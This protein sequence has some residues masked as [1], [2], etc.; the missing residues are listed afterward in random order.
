MIKIFTEN[1]FQMNRRLSFK[2]K[3]LYMVMTTILVVLVQF[4]ANATVRRVGY[5]GP[6][7][8]G[9]DYST[10]ALAQT[11]SA[12][13]D[14]IYMFRGNYGSITIT[15]Q[16]TVI[17]TGYLLDS[18]LTGNM[19]GN[20]FQQTFKTTSN[21]SVIFDVGSSNSKLYGMEGNI[22]IGVN[23][24]SN[25]SNIEIHRCYVI[26]SISLYG[27]TLNTK[28]YNC[29]FGISASISNNGTS[30]STNLHIYNCIS[31][32]VSDILSWTGNN[33]T[34]EL[35]NST[36]GG[37]S[38]NN[39]SAMV[40]YN[41]IFVNLNASSGNSVNQNCI[42]NN[43]LIRGLS[44]SYPSLVGSSNV[45]VPTATF[46]ITGNVMVGYPSQLTFS[47]D[48][49]FQLSASSPAI[50][51]GLGGVNA[52]AYGGTLPYKLSGIPTIPSIYKISSPQG[53]NPSGN[54]ITINFSTKGNN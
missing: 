45:Y 47:A 19:K 17:G 52:G 40:V 27:T 30:T 20:G 13:G 21:S 46:D 42:F 36:C 29:L 44:S 28:V 9:V 1:T 49:R 31:L 23:A 2:F 32:S 51:I 39:A 33:L 50:G 35:V 54:T 4:D 41:N 48:A 25:L 8:L 43:N 12:N 15:K 34:G 7:L 26:S 5:W 53:N 18:L 37:L 6:P 16:L 10:F 14:T 3:K 22:Q 38:V 24:S 11:A